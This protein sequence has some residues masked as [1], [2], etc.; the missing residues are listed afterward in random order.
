[1][2]R[3]ICSSAW[4]NLYI[5]GRPVA[6]QECGSRR[7]KFPPSFTS[8]KTRDNRVPVPHPVFSPRFKFAV[9]H[10]LQLFVTLGQLYE[11]IIPL[12]SHQFHVM[13]EIPAAM[14]ITYVEVFSISMP[15]LSNVSSN[16]LLNT[17]GADPPPL[18]R[19]FHW[20]SSSNWFP[21]AGLRSDY[22]PRRK[23]IQV[24]QINKSSCQ[25]RELTLFVVYHC[26]YWLWLE[27][28]LLTASSDPK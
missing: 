7:S 28:W 27:I 12:Y 9:R 3:D 23:S 15:V 4:L 22:H 5:S 14:Q 20:I 26:P 11:V 8:S 21:L 17:V 19:I 2:V 6:H 1:M 13:E 18:C 10:K 16:L 24:C 25:P